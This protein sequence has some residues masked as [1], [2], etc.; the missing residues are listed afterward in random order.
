[1]INVFSPAYAAD[2]TVDLTATRRLSQRAK[3]IALFDAAADLRCTISVNEMSIPGALA[4]LT[5]W[6][7]AH[8]LDVERL[9]QPGTFGGRFTRHTVQLGELHQIAVINLEME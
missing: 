1:V 8:D 5:L 2:S 4:M 9:E 3:L 7:G 6:A